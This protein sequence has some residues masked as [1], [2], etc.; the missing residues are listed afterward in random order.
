EAHRDELE[1]ARLDLEPGARTLLVAYGVTAGAM[2]AAVGPA[3]TQ[4]KRVS[5]AVV[6]SLWPVP[7]HLLR[8]AADGVERIVVG[9]L[10]PGLYCREVRSL[11]PDKEVVSLARIDGQLITPEMF[12]EQS[13]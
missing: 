2:T 5:S 1:L 4:A 12:V 9:E 8:Q 11:F 6:Q 7:E 3:R 10:N 13:L